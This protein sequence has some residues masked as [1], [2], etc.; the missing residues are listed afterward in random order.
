MS[1]ASLRWLRSYLES[2]GEAT[3]APGNASLV[4]LCAKASRPVCRVRP[5]RRVRPVFGSIARLSIRRLAAEK[6]PY[7][8]PWSERSGGSRRGL[9]PSVWLN[10]LI[11][12]AALP[13][14]VTFQSNPLPLCLCG[15]Q[16]PRTAFLRFLRLSSPSRPCVSR[17]RDSRG[18][19]LFERTGDPVIRG[20]RRRRG[21]GCGRSV[22][23]CPRHGSPS[24]AR[25]VRRRSC[26][27]DRRA[28]RESGG[29]LRGRGCRWVHRRG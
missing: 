18:I 22:R 1:A 13:L 7:L 21:A 10:F 26:R 6:S 15:K 3:E 16:N 23:R 12:L 27:P 2:L 8:I 29:R 14:C 24:R 25:A 28:D 5:V 9:R 19:P 20:R 17:I 4:S 11:P